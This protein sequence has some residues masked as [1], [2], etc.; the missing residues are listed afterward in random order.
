M[1][2][3]QNHE[4]TFA[5]QALGG[6]K[7]PGAML[8][9]IPLLLLAVT[10]CGCSRTTGEASSP[11]PAALVEEAPPPLDPSMKPLTLEQEEAVADA[12]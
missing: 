3:L 4:D 10:L 9:T 1:S 2:L 7:K 6:G 8:R 12:K 11:R 5:R